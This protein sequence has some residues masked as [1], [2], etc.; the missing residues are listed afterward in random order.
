M[1][2]FKIH[3][4][5]KKDPLSTPLFHYEKYN[6]THQII[7]SG[8][9]SLKNSSAPE[10][11]GNEDTSNPEELLLSALSSCHMLTFLAVASKKGFI[12]ES[13]D[14]MPI[15]LLDKNT[16][17]KM[18]VTEIFLNPVAVFNGAPPTEEILN[19]IHQLAHKNCF[20]AQSIK[21]KVH[22]QFS[23]A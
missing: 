20:I 22:I 5:W 15:A 17:G 3:L 13:Y 10:Y 6:R 16:D 1:S 7:F 18:A 23:L 19:T 2:S 12:V 8:D 9:Q 21:C 14:D 11:Y 4:H